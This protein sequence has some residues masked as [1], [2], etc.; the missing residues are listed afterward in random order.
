MF[1]LGDDNSKL[2]RRG[3]VTYGLIAL[4]VLVFLYEFSLGSESQ[5]L[6]DFIM[7]WGAVPER[8]AA[9]DGLI[10]LLTSMFLHGG[11]AHL[12]GNMLF[13]FVFGDNVED[14]FGHVKYLAFYLIT[15]LI[16]TAAHILL[17]LNSASAG[18]PSVGAS[19]AISGVLGAYIV[20]FRSNSVKVLLGRFVQTVPAWMMIGLWAVQQFIATFATITTTSQTSGGVAYAAHAGGFIA[21]VVIGFVLS[22]IQPA[23]QLAQR[24]KA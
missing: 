23:P 16:A 9:G 15:G 2:R 19:G 22:R 14:A 10:T 18:I 17:N 24:R 7:T 20:M 11:W 5:A 1:P 8:I 6:Q 12:I 4:N 21:G 3:Y 13:L